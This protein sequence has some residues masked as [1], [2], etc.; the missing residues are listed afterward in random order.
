MEKR[1]GLF[2]GE[3]WI[4]A[5]LIIIPLIGIL[6]AYILP[7]ISHKKVVMAENKEGMISYSQFLDEVETK[8]VK[9][10]KIVCRKTIEGEYTDNSKFITQIPYYDK[11]LIEILRKNK[12]ILWHDEE[13]P[14]KEDS[15]QLTMLKILLFGTAFMIFI[16]WIFY[17]RRWGLLRKTSL[18][19]QIIYWEKMPKQMDELIKK[20][21]TLIELIKEKK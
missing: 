11:N 12:V 19:A 15:F 9:E 20:L 16:F 14:R 1:R 7:V 21:D 17:N 8:K 2:E 4:M 18:G 6:I 5:S 13:P 10:V 3:I